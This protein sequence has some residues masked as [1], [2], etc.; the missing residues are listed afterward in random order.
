MKQSI[1][2]SFG[3]FNVSTV[4]EDVNAGVRTAL[5]TPEKCVNYWNDQ[6]KGAAGYQENKEFLI[7]ILL[8]TKLIPIGF[9]VVSIGT[10]NETA[11]HPRELMRPL[12]VGAAHSFVIMHNH[13]SGDPTPSQADCKFTRRIREVSE[14]MMINLCD[15]V[16]IGDDTNASF[17]FRESGMI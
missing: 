4:K 10:L 16:I 1:Q 8:N 6:V 13:P 5:D 9:N 3:Q 14:M 2:Y 7:V 15:H 12:I 11:A 17:S